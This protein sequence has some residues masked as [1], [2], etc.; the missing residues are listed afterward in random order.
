M[1]MKT[2]IAQIIRTNPQ[3]KVLKRYSDAKIFEMLSDLCHS[4]K[5]PVNVTNMSSF[6]SGLDSDL[7]GM[8][9]NSSSVE[10]EGMVYEY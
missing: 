1:D 3:I 2:E 8:F 4:E 6:A 5:L 9:S 7:E 10:S